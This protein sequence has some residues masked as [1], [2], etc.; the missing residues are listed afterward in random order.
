LYV[1]CYAGRILWEQIREE[2]T[3]IKRLRPKVK[4]VRE[5]VLRYGKMKWLMNMQN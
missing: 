1:K 4:E 3:E 2:W 5:P